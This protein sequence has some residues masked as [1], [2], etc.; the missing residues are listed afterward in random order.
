MTADEQKRRA[1]EK[2][3]EYV[4]PGMR[5]GLGTGSTA[6]HFVD[7]VGKSVAEGLDVLCVPTSE[8]TLLQAANLKIRLT[9]L[10]ETPGLDLTVDGADEI[11]PELA[12][13]KG[14]GGAHLREK[15][16]AAASKEMIVIADRSKHVTCLGAFPLPLEIAT[17]GA[18]AT[19]LAI[20]HLLHILGLAGDISQR[21]KHGKPFVSDNGNLI[22]DAHL[23]RIEDPVTLAASISSIP[24][25]VEHGLFTGLATR[26]IVAGPEGVTILD[27]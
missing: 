1:A 15:I 13:I 20:S 11:G 17:F 3:L 24:G 25:M 9:T 22:Y 14:G 8:A 23:G 2:A 19:V 10:D 7:L 16:V 21:M 5:L 18:R 26:A 6:F 27:T 4:K 12:L